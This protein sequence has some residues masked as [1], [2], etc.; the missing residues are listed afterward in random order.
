MKSFLK[1]NLKIVFALSL[2]VAVALNFV[3]CGN[4][5]TVYD[6]KFLEKRLSMPY[7]I[8]GILTQDGEKYDVTVDGV[9]SDDG[10]ELANFKIEYTSGDVTKGIV[11]EF[12]DDGVF[13]YFDDLRFKTN[14]ELFTNLEVLKTAFEKLAEPYTEKYVTDTTPVNGIDLLE[15]GVTDDIY[16]DIKAFVNKTDGSIVRLSALSNGCELILDVKDFENVLDASP[17]KFDETNPI[18]DV[19]DDYIEE[20]REVEEA[21]M[22]IEPED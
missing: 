7:R 22:E 13:I 15:I 5:P 18:F 8:D 2:I 12:F 16:G 14:S 19:V 10:T 9:T 6:G 11:V 21:E 4:A 17:N 1:L 3:S 20:V